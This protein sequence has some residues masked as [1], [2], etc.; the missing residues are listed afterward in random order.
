MIWINLPAVGT[1]VSKIE[2]YMLPSAIIKFFFN[3]VPYQKFLFGLYE[4]GLTA[5][6]EMV[7]DVRF[8]KLDLGLLPWIYDQKDNPI[9]T[10][11]NSLLVPLKLYKR[12]YI[13]TQIKNILYSTLAL[14]LLS[15]CDGAV[16][17]KQ[18][19]KSVLVH[20]IETV[21]EAKK[22]VEAIN[23]KAA[24]T[25]VQ[26]KLTSQSANGSNLYARKCASCHGVDA[27][28]SALNTSKV[29]AGWDAKKTKDAL[30]AYKKGNYG[31][32][33][34]GIMEGQSRAL[35]DSEIKLISEYISSL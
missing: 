12:I 35:N 31:G 24:Q 26:I 3:D 32:K 10:L 5:L 21:E 11:Q 8:K 16:E 19:A 18:E 23:K 27:K 4:L 7:E 6:T 20:K 14:V 22:S 15:A 2:G 34:K 30:N 17:Q 28:R 13:L 9:R 33:M 1:V 25:A 29:I